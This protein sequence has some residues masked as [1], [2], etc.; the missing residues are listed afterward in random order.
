MAQIIGR[1][2]NGEIYTK[3]A[4]GSPKKVSI[5]ITDNSPADK[6][7]ILSVSGGSY[8]TVSPDGKQIAFVARGEVFVTSVE[9][10]TTKQITSTPEGEASPTFGADNRTLTYASERNGYWNLYTAKIVRD[11]DPN[12]P[13]ATLIEEKPLFKD[14]NIDRSHPQYSPDGKELAFVEGRCRLMVLNIESGKV[15]QI[16]DGSQHYNT[17]G[18]ISYQWSPDGKWFAISYTGN[19]HDPYSDIGLVSAQGGAITNLTNTG[20]FDSDPQWVLDGNALL[21]CTDRYGMRSHAS[22]GSLEDVMIVFL[23]R[24]T[25]EEYRMSKE[26]YEIY[27]EA[28]KKQDEEAKKENKESKADNKKDDKKEEAKKDDIV[29]ELDNIDERIVRLTPYSGSMSGYTLDKEGTSL[30]YIISYEG[31]YDMWQLNLR[32]RSNKIVQKGIG[33]GSFAWDK[34]RENMFL[35]GGS[36]RKFKGGTGSPTSISARC[37]M[38]LDREA[39]REYMFDRIYRQE[40]ERFYHKDM[41]GVNWEA[42]CDNY[43]RFLPHINNNFDFAEMTSELLGELNVSHTGCSYSRPGDSSADVTANLG[44][45]YDF[46]RK[47][48]GLLATSS[49]KSTARLF[50]TVRITSRCSTA[51]QVRPAH[52][53][54]SIVPIVASAGRR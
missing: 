5:N 26:E 31:S 53:F 22:W 19:K 50:S 9:Y 33:S 38:R 17:S 54:R 48:D 4:T 21:F 7:S 11:D 34:K 23:N 1:Q 27:K 25:Y 15:R 18:G 13:N 16:T 29:I 43:A 51:R 37:E 35:L 2:C 42:M 12:F 46:N 36:M 14:D 3:S 40:K 10:T 52:S 24:K 44:V 30:Y 49:R 39:E 32:D 47:G 8:S 6:T 20:Y 45:F 41:H 28:E